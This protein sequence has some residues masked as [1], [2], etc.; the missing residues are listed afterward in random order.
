MWCH[1]IFSVKIKILEKKGC[2]GLMIYLEKNYVQ[3][4]TILNESDID[5]NLISWEINVNLYMTSYI[6]KHMEV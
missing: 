5:I 6:S 3:L 2:R 4:V 1:K